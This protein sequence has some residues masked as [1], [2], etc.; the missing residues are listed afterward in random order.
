MAVKRTKNGRDEK[1][2]F[3]KG[4]PGG[5]RP[6]TPDEVKTAFKAMADGFPEFARKALAD[7]E[8]GMAYKVDLYKMI[9]DR[10]YGKPVQAVEGKMDFSTDFVLEIE[11]ENHDA[12][13]TP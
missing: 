1:G 8:V 7:P 6:K 12:D 4:N 2:R 5:G 9:L 3:V 10:A 13:I 11:G